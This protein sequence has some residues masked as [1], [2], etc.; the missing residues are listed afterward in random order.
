MRDKVI[1]VTGGFGVLGRAVAEAAL[2][3]EAYVAI[4]GRES[5][6]KIPPRDRLL[7]LGGVD[8]TDFAAAKEAMDAVAARFGKVDGLANIAGGFRWQT[9]ADGDLAAWTDLFRMNVLTAATASKAALPYLRQSHGAIVNVASAPAK[10]AGTGMGAYAASKAGVLRLT[11]S[12]AEEEK[13]NGIRVNAVLPTIID[14]PRNR[15]EMP[16]ADF[17][18]WVKPEEI[19]KAILFLLSSDATAITGAELLAAGRT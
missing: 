14:T 11:E 19:A 13:N 15:A 10:K 3:A 8:L 18:R 12:L 7:V 5:A 2:A 16:K 17:S 9:L 4:P 1:V 6:D